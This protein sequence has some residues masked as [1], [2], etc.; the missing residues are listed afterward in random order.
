MVLST[1][2][3]IRIA[4]VQQ[5]RSSKPLMA[6][7]KGN[8]NHGFA[9]QNTPYPFLVYSLH[10]APNLYSWGGVLTEA[11]FD[12]VAFS[13]DEGEATSIAQLVF[14]T[15][16]DQLL[17]VTGQTS[18]KSRL[19]SYIDLSDVDD[20]GTRYF[21][22]GGVYE[23]WTTQELPVARSFTFTGDADIS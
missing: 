18:L 15:L 20:T 6:A 17:V 13:Y 19:T 22:R 16:Q 23:F 4:L 7:I 10:Y 3:P 11:G 21:S 5:L 9:P 12:V 1:V 14:A 8:V 2:D